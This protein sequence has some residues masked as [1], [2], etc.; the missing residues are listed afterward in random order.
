VK[1]FALSEVETRVARAVEEAGVCN[2]TEDA[3]DQKPVIRAETVRRLLFGFPVTLADEVEPRVVS[4]HGSGVAITGA[5]IES[6]L[7][8]EHGRSASGGPLP[9]LVLDYCTIPAPIRLSYACIHHL[10]F[11]G[12]KLTQIDGYDVHIAGSLDISSVGTAEQGDEKTGIDGLGLCAVSLT[13]SKIDGKVLAMDSTLVGRAPDSASKDGNSSS[14]A[15]NLWSTEIGGDLILLENFQA[16]GGVE[17][18]F[19]DIGGTCHAMGSFFYADENRDAF[20]AFSTH[21]H[22]D[23]Y[24]SGFENSE[25]GPLIAHGQANLSQVDISGSLTLVHAIIEGDLLIRNARVGNTLTIRIL[26]DENPRKA[27]SVREKL[28]FLLKLGGLRR[29]TRTINLEYTKVRVLSDNNG[30]GFP[31]NCKLLLEGFEYEALAEVRS[32]GK[33]NPLREIAVW[34]AIG[35]I[36]VAIYISRLDGLLLHYAHVHIPALIFAAARSRYALFGLS[37]VAVCLIGNHF[38]EPV[39]TWKLRRRWLNLQYT[40]RCHIFNKDEYSPSPYEHLTK[41]LRSHGL[42]EDA[43]RIAIE[44]LRL[45]RKMRGSMLFKPIDILFS[46]TFR[47][48]L[49]STRAIMTLCFFIGFGW[50]SVAVANC[51]FDPSVLRTSGIHVVDRNVKRLPHID[52]VLVI[53][54]SAV[55]SFVLTDTGTNQPMPALG[56]STTQNA[57]TEELPCRRQI[58]P[59]LYALDVFIPALDINQETRC[60]ISTRPSALWWRVGRAVYAILGWIVVSLTILTCS[61]I[62]R[63]QAEA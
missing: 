9:P 47:Y 20:S 49:S 50:L 41:T 12:S 13:G 3:G 29:I 18:A 51:G 10:S 11:S 39:P 6:T 44:R 57:S 27:R 46:F 1:T 15:L 30:Q 32:L 54:V 2:F 59:L 34:G 23:V 55:N 17:F 35:L 7:D 16:I 22:G 28:K 38:L 24:L 43:R 63:R 19:A 25:I 52:P 40:S 31:D 26:P 4:V 14:C 5:Y 62:L 56:R 33:S 21:V 61:G 58:E 8:L 53:N 48:G 42:F 45:Q 36:W 60:T 37:A